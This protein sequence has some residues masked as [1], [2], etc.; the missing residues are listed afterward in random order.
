MPLFI[1]YFHQLE[2]CWIQLFINPR[3][4]KVNNLVYPTAP[5]SYLT[6]LCLSLPRDCSETS[7]QSVTLSSASRLQYSPTML[8]P[9][10][11]SYNTITALRT[12]LD[13]RPSSSL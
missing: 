13:L 3:K 10:L 12:N 5:P 11:E 9:A 4:Y 7:L 6:P 2:K 1:H 8:T